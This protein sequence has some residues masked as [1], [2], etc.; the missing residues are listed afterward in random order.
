[1]DSTMRGEQILQVFKGELCEKETDPTDTRRE[2]LWT[3]V[4]WRWQG[5]GNHFSNTR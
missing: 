4:E 5:L 3:S 1:M 2:A